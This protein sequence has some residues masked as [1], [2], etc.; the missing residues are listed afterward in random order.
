MESLLQRARDFMLGRDREKKRAEQKPVKKPE[1]VSGKERLVNR[2]DPDLVETVI[3]PAE[4]GVPEEQVEAPVE[5]VRSPVT[6]RSRREKPRI[7]DL[8]KPGAEPDAPA[9]VEA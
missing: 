2:I 7:E 9:A 8:P 1:N 5:E 3:V 6:R 4:E